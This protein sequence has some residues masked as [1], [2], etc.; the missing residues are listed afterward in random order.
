MLFHYHY[1]TPYLEETETFYTE[2]GFTVHQRIGRLNGSFQSFNPPL[3]WNDFREN[4]P[5]FRIIELKKGN[6]NVTVGYGKKPIFD[7]IGFIVSKEEHDLVCGK[8]GKLGWTVEEDERRTFISTPYGFRLELQTNKD[9]LGSGMEAIEE[10]R[11][12][13]KKEGLEQ[14]LLYVFEKRVPVH[15]EVKEET[16][17]LQVKMN[18]LKSCTDPNKV[19]LVDSIK[20]TVK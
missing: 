18:G 4:P 11:V 8:A 16:R 13:V 19:L 17:L 2:L 10:M 6:I 14:D 7:H 5:L 9:V 12:S 15:A 1:W 3:S 20:E